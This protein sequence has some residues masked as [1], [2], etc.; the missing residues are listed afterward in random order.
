MPFSYKPL[1]RLLVDRGMQKT[2]LIPA[3]GMGPSTL[4][5]FEKGG[6][7]SLDV[8]DRLCTYFDCQPNDILEHI[9]E[10]DGDA[11]KND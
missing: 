5:K 1:F 6:F 3:I 11:I 2:D 4:A 9:K 7:I 8:L 10:G